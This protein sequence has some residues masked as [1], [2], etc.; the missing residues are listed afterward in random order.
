[1][2]YIN[3]VSPVVA[4]VVTK[5]ELTF[6]SAVVIARGDA[7]VPVM[8]PLVDVTGPLKVVEAMMVPYMQVRRISL[9]VV[10]RDGLIHRKAR[11]GSFIA[12]YFG[13]CKFFS[14]V[15]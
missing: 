11:S 13:E 12:H 6:W 5:A 15:V 1:L 8:N 4:E 7:A 9:H 10:R 3:L 14:L 2:S